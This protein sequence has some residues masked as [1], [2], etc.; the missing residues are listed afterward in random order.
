MRVIGLLIASLMV[1][2]SWAKSFYEYE[3]DIDAKDLQV[4]AINQSSFLIVGTQFIVDEEGGSHWG[5]IAQ[6]ISRQSNQFKRVSAEY[7]VDLSK[8][9][10]ADESLQ[11]KVLGGKSIGEGYRVMIGV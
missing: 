10:Q 1:T 11:V 3:V 2:T 9:V 8:T 7:E 4:M 6:R 5:L